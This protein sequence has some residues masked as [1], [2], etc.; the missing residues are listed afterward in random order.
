MSGCIKRQVE[1]K[2]P[3][4]NSSYY[5]EQETVDRILDFKNSLA[6]RKPTRNE[7]KNLLQYV[8]KDISEEIDIM[9]KRFSR[10]MRYD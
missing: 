1:L 2:D 3:K 7:L 6:G 4:S 9:F 5:L 10:G 8:P